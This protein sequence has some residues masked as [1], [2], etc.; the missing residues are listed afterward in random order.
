VPWHVATKYVYF[1]FFS[2]TMTFENVDRGSPLTNV[3][4]SL[5]ESASKVIILLIIITCMH[6]FIQV[7]FIEINLYV[8]EFTAHQLVSKVIK[9][10]IVFTCT[11]VYFI[12]INLLYTLILIR[13][14]ATK[15]L[16]RAVN[17]PSG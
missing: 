14:L 3:P 7:Y 2:P 16:I 4:P 17:S 12:K 10:F 5:L 8:S 6:V 9:R 15:R 1:L 11:H 13:A